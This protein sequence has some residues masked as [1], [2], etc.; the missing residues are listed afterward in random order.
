[1]T[2]NRPAKA[3]DKIEQWPLDD[4]KEY[5][6]NARTHSPEQVE[7]IARSLQEFGWMSPILFD[8]TEAT[9]IAG[10]GRL[11]AAR[12]IRDRGLTI[13]NSSQPG[14]IVLDLFGGSGSTLIACE[15]TK[16]V[17][18]LME[19]DPRYV[20]VIVRSW[21][22]LTGKKAILES[23]GRTFADVEAERRPANDNS[24]DGAESAVA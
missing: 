9:I 22:E 21:Q 20:D 18:R 6:R 12:L 11:M 24:D 2:A 3:A 7:K 13:P 8:G 16:R 1:M 15:K 4:L 23:D 5:E 19:L 17:A 14:D 10:H